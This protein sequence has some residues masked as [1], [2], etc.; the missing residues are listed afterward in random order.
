MKYIKLFLVCLVGITAVH[1][2]KK[3]IATTKSS[4]GVMLN[5]D[6]DFAF[7]D[8]DPRR[9][10]QLLRANVDGHAALGIKTYIFS[11]GAGSD[12][13]YYPTKQKKTRAYIL[14]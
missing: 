6:G 8:P 13:L 12:V 2:Q 7:V 3:N 4:F 1:A 11:L 9:A 10:E 5:E 14:L